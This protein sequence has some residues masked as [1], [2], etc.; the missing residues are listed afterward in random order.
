MASEMGTAITDPL[1]GS[2]VSSPLGS[3]LVRYG[4]GLSS[5]AV[6]AAIAFFLLDGT[7]QLV[8][9]AIAAFEALFVPQ[10]LKMAA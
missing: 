10:F 6:I 7:I 4:I 3:P 8:A 2:L 9:F 5:A 1:D